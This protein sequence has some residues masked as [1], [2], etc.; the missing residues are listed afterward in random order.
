MPHGRVS[1]LLSSTPAWSEFDDAPGARDEPGILDFLKN[2]LGIKW[3]SFE[4]DILH[5]KI[6]IAE[7]LHFLAVLALLSTYIHLINTVQFS[8]PKD[9]FT[10]IKDHK[11]II[12]KYDK[13]DSKF[14]N[15]D[16]FFYA[17]N[18]DEKQQTDEV[19]TNVIG[20]L[21]GITMSSWI[22]VQFLDQI[23]SDSYIALGVNIGFLCLFIWLLFFIYNASLKQQ[24][25]P[26]TPE[27]KYAY[28]FYPLLGGLVLVG[29]ALLIRIGDGIANIAASSK[30][31]EP[32]G[33]A[34]ERNRINNL[35]KA[36]KQIFPRLEENKTNQT[37]DP[38]NR[39]NLE[40]SIL[41]LFFV[42]G[43]GQ[44]RGMGGSSSSDLMS[45]DF[46]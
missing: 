35:V 44:A 19:Y 27:G 14:F 22:K 5:L 24:G 45:T 37:Y 38:Y 15:K 29:E 2:L 26:T 36:M 46:I 31:N 9:F 13:Q 39:K 16:S 41:S 42:D 34:I 10:N 20:F 23:P 3:K 17:I 30:F 21:L 11:K 32:R 28:A 12:E 40:G 4:L 1:N 6:G 43:S 33:A 7:V 25:D 18:P 8:K